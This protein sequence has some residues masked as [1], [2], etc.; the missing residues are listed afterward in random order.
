[1]HKLLVVGGNGFL[2]KRI[3]E[4]AVRR[5]IPTVSV[6]RSGNAP[7]PHTAFDEQ[8]IKNVSWQRGDVFRP[9][10]F[11]E[12]LL[13]ASHVVHTLGILL[14]NEQY[15]HSLQAGFDPA[16]W[17]KGNNPLRKNKNANFTYEM[18]N[19][20]GP[21][22]L[23]QYLKSLETPLQ[24]FTY[25]SADSAFPLVPA[26]Y[27]ESKRKAECELS[28]VWDQDKVKTFFV[29]PGF[30]FDELKNSPDMKS[31]RSTVRDL[32]EVAN[33][34]NDRILGR[35]FQCINK[36]I[37]PTLS[38]QQVARATLD[39]ISDDNAKAGVVTLEEIAT[40]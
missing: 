39:K 1:M 12:H 16:D 2:G 3:C 9:R 23:A 15:K 35:R 40:Y 19:T 32:L 7:A 33:C 37:R 27:I 10:S 14:E 36:A 38:T 8:W 4:E 18:M 34:A 25:I 6:S 22:G 31:A 5:G 21:V 28:K 24:S 13:Q 17:L 11:L 20:R 30:M 26:G 29:R